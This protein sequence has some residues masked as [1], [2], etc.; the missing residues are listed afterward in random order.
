MT[1]QRIF[2]SQII[3]TP[4]PGEVSWTASYPTDGLV[5]P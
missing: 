5:N 2:P 4:A 3:G 1:L